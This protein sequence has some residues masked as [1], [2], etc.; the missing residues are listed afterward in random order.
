VRGRDEE[1]A[2]LLHEALAL[3]DAAGERETAAKACRELGYVEVQAARGVSA[4]R[5]LI[6]AGQL[7]ESERER[8][9]VLGVRGMALSDRAHYG[10]A[11]ELLGLS[12]TGAR[13]AGDVRQAAWSLAILG[14]A[15][16]LRG[17]TADAVA[18]IDES[19]ALVA[20]ER[21]LAFQPF[22]ESLRA[23]AA[24]VAHDHGRAIELLEHAFSLGCYLGDPCWEAMAAR[25][26]GLVHEAAGERADALERLRDATARAARVA[27][28]Y[29]W[30]HAACL[31][32]LVGVAIDDDASDAREL[33][34]ELERIAAHGDLRELIVRAALHRARLGDP[35]GIEAARLLG[36]TIDNAALH[37]ELAVLA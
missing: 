28:P 14:R 26:R 30:I 15:R 21:W 36:E 31:E 10:A 20:Q 37:A 33:L 17:E 11:I 27:D 29:V 1:G 35:G 25:A 18:A 8:A 3:A 32:T 12:V 4:G 19:L 16:L 13:A 5:W 9:A 24:L 2:A 22:P 34:D 6:R 7:A 23:E